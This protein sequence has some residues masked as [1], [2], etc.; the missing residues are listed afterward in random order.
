MSSYP[1]RWLTP[2][3]NGQLTR[4]EQVIAFIDEYGLV[5]KD[6]IAGKAGSKLV[7]RDWQRNLIRDLFAEDNNGRLIHRTA[8]IGMPRKNGKSAL[9]SSLAL[10]SLFLGDNGGEVY[11]CAAEKEQA[12]IVFGDAKRMIEASPDLAEMTKVYRDAIEVLDTGSVYRVLSAEAYSKE[13]LSPTFVVFDELHA[14]PNRELFDV[15]ALGMGA[16]QEPMLLGITTAG[17]KTDSTGQDSV[18]YSLYQYGQKVATGESVD[19]SFF[20]AW[21]EADQEASH[22]DPQTWRDANPGFGDLNN[23]DDFEAM[24]RRTPEAEFRTKRCNQWVSSQNA[25]LPNGT[26]DEI[27]S[28]RELDPDAEYVLGFDGSFSGDCTAIIGV[29]IPRDEDEKPYVFLVQAW[30]KQPTDRDDWRVDTLDVENRIMK[31]V[32]DFPNTIEI[33]C[34]PFRWQR[35]MAVL[36]DKGLPIVEWPSTS[37]RR[38]VPACN[39]FYE[40]VVEKQIDHDGDPTL[41]RH[42]SN[43]VVKIDQYGPRIVKEHRHSPRKI[44]AA[45]AGIIALDRA[46]QIREKKEP[47]KVPQFFI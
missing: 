36:Q 31:F 22:T 30:E 46:L 16:R 27:A 5:T 3:V 4:A 21:W 19:P 26:W 12:R 14:S 44:D 7:L 23:E 32:A 6:T 45:V 1:P 10:W 20:M 29:Q 2:V 35:S 13:G 24:A 39:K 38:M 18:A 34:D 28:P 17:V 41:A 43:A 40:Q 9:G 37:V 42:L 8:L 33:A 11:S 25:W 15:M 47:P